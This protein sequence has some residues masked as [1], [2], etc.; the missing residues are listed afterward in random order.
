MTLA[1]AVLSRAD[2]QGTSELPETAPVRGVYIGVD[3]TNPTLIL[4]IRSFRKAGV[5][6]TSFTFRRHK[7]NTGFQPD[8]DNIHLGD[9]VDRRY[10]YRLPALLRALWRMVKHGDVLRDADFIYARNLDLLAL[11]HFARLLTRSKAKLVYEVEDVQAIFFKKSTAGAL[12]RRVEGWLLQRVDLLV[13]MS[14]GFLR[15]Y[16]EPVHGWKGPSFVLENKLQLGDRPETPT[17]AGR[18]WEEITD[19]WVIGW[20]GTLRCTKSMALLEEIAVAL[21]PRVEIYTRGY[22]TETGLDA[23]MEIVNRHPNWT[24]DGEYTIPDD[25]EEMYGRV[26]FSWCLDFL[27][28]E[29][30][31]PLLLACRMYQGGFYGSVPLVAEGSEMEDWLARAGVGHAFPAPHAASIIDFLKSVTPGEYRKERARIMAER[32]ALFLEDGSDMRN[33]LETMQQL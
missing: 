23:Y 22:P 9:T 15:G 17:P 18:V 20:F 27:D 33:L 10:L 24:Y 29:G 16:F 32:R 31:S 25:L 8:W 21:G 1:D 4:R 6:L 5:R 30:N 13:V 19:R 26:H 28:E 12:F 2:G 7:F 14:P 3:A 11:G